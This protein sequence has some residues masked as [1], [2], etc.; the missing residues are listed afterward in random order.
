MEYG[1]FLQWTKGLIEGFS[2]LGTWLTQE[3]HVGTWTT[4]PMILVSVT[5]LTVFIAAAV[6][7]W[8]IN[9]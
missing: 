4:T 6:I 9:L 3:I 5:G 2:D 1:M 8:V 7:L